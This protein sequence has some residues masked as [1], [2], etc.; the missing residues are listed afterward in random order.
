VAKAK[1]CSNSP[2]FSV[3]L[4]LLI[5]RATPMASQT[6]A[7]SPQDNNSFSFLWYTLARYF[8]LMTSVGL[9]YTVFLEAR[10]S[11]VHLA[12]LGHSL[13][14]LKLCTLDKSNYAHCIP[15]TPSSLIQPPRTYRR[16][17]ARVFS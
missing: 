4:E 10:W 2:R 16:G 3:N 15:S 5:G 8:I 12:I 1:P 17:I 7:L 14:A 6:S 11:T 13:A 9:S